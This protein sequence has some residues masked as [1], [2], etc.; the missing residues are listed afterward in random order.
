MAGAPLQLAG[1]SAQAT[2]FVYAVVLIYNCSQVPAYSGSL[3][4]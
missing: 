4:F 1:N 3:I 2:D